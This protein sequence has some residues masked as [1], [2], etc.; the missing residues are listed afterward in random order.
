MAPKPSTPFADALSYLAPAAPLVIGIWR[1]SFGSQWRDDQALLAAVGQ[2]PPA[3][4]GALSALLASV[5]VELPVG[6][7]WL[8]AALV[9]VVALS[10]CGF[11]IFSL[12]RHL[13]GRLG[14]SPLAGNAA[15]LGSAWLVTLGPCWQLEATVGGGLTVAV[16]LCLL[17]IWLSREAEAAWVP[18]ALALALGAALAENWAAAAALALGLTARLSMRRAALPWSRQTVALSAALF[19]LVSVGLVLGQLAR[20]GGHWS[21]LGVAF[22]GE[23][24]RT[25]LPNQALAL[26]DENFTLLALGIAALGACATLFRAQTRALALALVVWCIL[27]WFFSQAVEDLLG[28]DAFAPFALLGLSA[29]GIFAGVGAASAF[30]LTRWRVPLARQSVGLLVTALFVL[31]LL[32]FERSTHVAGRRDHVASEAWT[33]EALS[34]LPPGS[35]LL[36][37]SSELAWHLWAAREIGGQR[38]DLI[39]APLRALERGSGSEELV[40]SEPALGPVVRDLRLSRRPT[41]FALSSLAVERPLFVQFDATWDPRLREHLVPHG[42]WVGFSPH[43]LGRS[44]RE[45]ATLASDQA[46]SR[47]VTLAEQPGSRDAGTLQVLEEQ[48]AEHALML[49]SLQDFHAASL[50][51]E[52]LRLIAPKHPALEALQ[53]PASQQSALALIAR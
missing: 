45:G 53:A 35:V 34:D 4:Q 15:A 27:G 46:F 17:G 39:I 37:K 7:K 50:F 47:V 6:G 12:T 24:G 23:V 10:L 3:I 5:A 41:E 29:V 51:A 44:D 18:F 1:A 14:V 20:S 2:G 22:A 19:G 13:A 48:L 52:K 25:R 8:R 28:L 38:P 16:S 43:A 33:D 31:A 30:T 36:L 26:V 40:R 32:G 49:F 9:S 21:D 11:L 42:F